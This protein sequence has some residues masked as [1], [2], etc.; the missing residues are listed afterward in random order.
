MP[1]YHGGGRGRTERSGRTGRQAGQGGTD[2]N[3]MDELHAGLGGRFDRVVVEDAPDDVLDRIVSA[4]RDRT[5]QSVAQGLGAR[6]A[7]RVRATLAFDDWTAGPAL[8][9]RGVTAPMAGPR[10]LVYAVD[11]AHGPAE[12]AISL[13]AGEPHRVTVVGQLLSDAGEPFLVEVV[14]AGAAVATTTC[15]A[16]GEF[17]VEAPADWDEIVLVGPDADVIIVREGEGVERP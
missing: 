9:L 12:V 6:L 8:A 7:A 15:S 16:N 17:S 1:M 2:V 4:F 13:Y 10:H 14:A 5:Q 11:G 3:E